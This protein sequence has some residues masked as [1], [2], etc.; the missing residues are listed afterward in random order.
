[1]RPEAAQGIATIGRLGPEP[2]MQA[3]TVLHHR[4]VQDFFV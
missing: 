1:M 4:P 3:N 2:D